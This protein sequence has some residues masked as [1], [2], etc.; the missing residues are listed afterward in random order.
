VTIETC[1]G[2]ENMR[3]CQRQ[4]AGKCWLTKIGLLST[5]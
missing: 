3:W 2:S 5:M 1:T 4:S